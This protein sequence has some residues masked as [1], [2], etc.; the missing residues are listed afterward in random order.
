MI[1][2]Y[3]FGVIVGAAYTGVAVVDQSAAHAVGGPFALV[4]IG[5]FIVVKRKLREPCPSENE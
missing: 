3:F 5:V 2:A 4:E 1:G